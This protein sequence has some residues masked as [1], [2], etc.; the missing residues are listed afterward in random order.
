VGEIQG[1]FKGVAAEHPYEKMKA[2]LSQKVTLAL[3]GWPKKVPL[4]LLGVRCVIVD[5]YGDV[6]EE[7]WYPKPPEVLFRLQPDT[8]PVT[9][10]GQFPKNW[11]PTEPREYRPWK[12]DPDNPD[13]V[14]YIPV[15]PKKK[16]KKNPS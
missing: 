2:E 9:L 16:K 8:P 14:T 5:E 6:E 12:L 1:V 15:K 13:V 7:K 3:D 4:K 11:E 10:D